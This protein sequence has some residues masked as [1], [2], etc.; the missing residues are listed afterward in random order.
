MD[1]AKDV[2]MAVAKRTGPNSRNEI[3]DLAS[4]FEYEPRAFG[5]SYSQSEWMQGGLCQ[6]ITQKVFAHSQLLKT[7]TSSKNTQLGLPAPR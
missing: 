6:P 1:G 5:L 7:D 2:R 3:Y 4:V